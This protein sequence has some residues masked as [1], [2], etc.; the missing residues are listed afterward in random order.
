MLSFPSPVIRPSLVLAN[1]CF[2]YL[3]FFS[4]FFNGTWVLDFTSLSANSVEYDLILLTATLGFLSEMMPV[5]FFII[6]FSGA[7]TDFTIHC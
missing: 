3:C 4:H 7:V 1:M 5:D 6:F 2:A